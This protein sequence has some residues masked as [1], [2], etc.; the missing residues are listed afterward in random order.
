MCVNC[1]LGSG[2]AQ[3]LFVA[4]AIRSGAR[5]SIICEGRFRAVRTAG[6]IDPVLE[7]NR[8]VPASNARCHH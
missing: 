6:S 7:R 8:I 3:T 4:N 1:V 2:A 5:S